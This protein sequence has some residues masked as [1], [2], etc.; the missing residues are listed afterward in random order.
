MSMTELEIDREAIEQVLAE[1]VLTNAREVAR[2]ADFPQQIAERAAREFIAS[3]DFRALVVAEIRKL[4]EH[5]AAMPADP[6]RL[7]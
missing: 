1:Q 7:H 6:R 5:F 2:Q 4:R 3:A